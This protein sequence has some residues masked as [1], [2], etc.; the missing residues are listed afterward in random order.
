MRVDV[1]KSKKFFVDTE[2]TDQCTKTLI[3]IGIASLDGNCFYAE[4]SDYR[5][6]QRSSFVKKYV[7]PRLAEAGTLETE[8]AIG[9]RLSQWIAS[10]QGR[11]RLA[12]NHSTDIELVYCYC[13]DQAAGQRI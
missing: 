12:Y 13:T 1:N 10:F 4:S 11:Q 8:S 6:E 5:I 2:F 7:L 9:Q 3:S